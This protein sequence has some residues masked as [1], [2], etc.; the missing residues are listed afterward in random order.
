M[1][2]D[3]ETSRVEAVVPNMGGRIGE[4]IVI[5]KGAYLIMDKWVIIIGIA[6][7]EHSYIYIAISLAIRRSIA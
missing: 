2:R 5:K 7:G 4:A 3:R 6:L 1:I